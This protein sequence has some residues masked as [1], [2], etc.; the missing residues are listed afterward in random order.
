MIAFANKEGRKVKLQPIRN[1]ALDGVGVQL[2]VAAALPLG[3]TRYRLWRRL[4]RPRGC[5][6]RGRK[7]SLPPGFDPWTVRPV[8]SCY[9]DCAIPA[10]L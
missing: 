7:I 9:L 3:T 2:R 6:E 8:T 1:P 5:P 10:A 4:G